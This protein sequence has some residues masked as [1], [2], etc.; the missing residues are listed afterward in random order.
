METNL[1]V[2]LM[3]TLV[4]TYVYLNIEINFKCFLCYQNQRRNY[5]GLDVFIDN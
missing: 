5:E 4:Y 2:I 1:T 3:W